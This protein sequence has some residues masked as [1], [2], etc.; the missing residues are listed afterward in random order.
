MLTSVM[1]RH[2]QFPASVKNIKAGDVYFRYYAN[3]RLWICGSKDVG[4]GCPYRLLNWYA[5]IGKEA[6]HLKRGGEVKPTSPVVLCLV[7]GGMRFRGCS[8]LVASLT[9]QGNT[10]HAQ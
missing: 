1:E 7:R 2:K 5:L 4:R 10:E 8:I 6:L 3:S 9:V